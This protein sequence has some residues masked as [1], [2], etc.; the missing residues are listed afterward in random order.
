MLVQNEFSKISNLAGES[1]S[2]LTRF[3]RD[4]RKGFEDLIAAIRGKI[5]PS[6][7]ISPTETKDRID[8]VTG[9]KVGEIEVEVEGGSHAQKEHQSL[10][11]ALSEVST[12]LFAIAVFLVC[13]WMLPGM[14][15]SASTQVPFL[16]LGQ[17]FNRQHRKGGEWFLIQFPLIPAFLWPFLF[18]WSIADAWWVSSG[19]V[20]SSESINS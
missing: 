11:L 6:S 1:Y 2:A 9:V 4:P 18:V 19:I 10:G 5:S 8:P 13:Y 3:A 15:L 12:S 17:H 7:N 14:D 16:F 20:A